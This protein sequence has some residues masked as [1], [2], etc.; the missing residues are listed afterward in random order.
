[1]AADGNTSIGFRI[2]G[3]AGFSR[4]PCLPD[5]GL[6]QYWPIGLVISG[7]PTSNQTGRSFR[8][9]G[10]SKN[11]AGPDLGPQRATSSTSVQ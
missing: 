10:H 7:P 5:L 11:R 2:D 4:R 3:A 6:C 9:D 8:F 1:M